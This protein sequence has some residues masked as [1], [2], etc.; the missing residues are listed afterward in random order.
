MR[1]TYTMADKKQRGTSVML[2]ESY[3]LDYLPGFRI[4]KK[5]RLP[6]PP[7]GKQINVLLPVFAIQLFTVLTASSGSPGYLR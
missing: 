6:V 1:I 5:R 2:I 4:S 3:L 7:R